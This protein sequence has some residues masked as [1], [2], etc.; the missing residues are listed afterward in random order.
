M[1]VVSSFYTPCCFI[2]S[3]EKYKRKANV[4]VTD[5][6]HDKDNRGR[7]VR[8]FLFV[9]VPLKKVLDYMVCQVQRQGSKGVIR[10]EYIVAENYQPVP[11]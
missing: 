1:V 4:L 8:Y 7:V 11:R 10:R 9:L 2:F 6:S 5:W 3:L